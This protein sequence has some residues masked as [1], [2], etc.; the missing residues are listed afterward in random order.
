M[1]SLA[2]GG[3]PKARKPPRRATLHPSDAINVVPPRH[4][5]HPHPAGRTVSKAKPS[6]FS[7]RKAASTRVRTPT[8]HI[9]FSIV[10]PDGHSRPLIAGRPTPPRPPPTSRGPGPSPPPSPGWDNSTLRL[11]DPS[12]WAT[13]PRTD[14]GLIRT[15]RSFFHKSIANGCTGIPLHE[16]FGG[17][18]VIPR[19]LRALNNNGIN[20]IFAES[21]VLPPGV[22]QKCRQ[23][24]IW[25]SYRGPMQ[26]LVW[27]Y[28]CILHHHMD[29]YHSVCRR[30]I[31]QTSR[32]TKGAA[33][34]D[35]FARLVPSYDRYRPHWRGRLRLFLL[36]Y[37]RPEPNSRF[38]VPQAGLSFARSAPHFIYDPCCGLAQ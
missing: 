20:G 19:R 5:N 14:V 35:P 38:A 11:C 8:V 24:Q 27:H 22:K 2:A 26:I 25:L 6:S 21:V 13:R 16:Q 9:H 7:G 1:K 33:L 4:S 29:T 32:F 31:T 12:T 28:C 3:L 23:L 10:E 36:V 30:A 15:V 17:S 34:R 18:P 37:R